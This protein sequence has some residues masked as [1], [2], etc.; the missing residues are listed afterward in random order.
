MTTLKEKMEAAAREERFEDA[1]RLRDRIGAVERTLERQQ[2]VGDPVAD[3]DVFGLAR[4]GG[5]VELQVLHVREGRVMGAAEYAFSGVQ[6]DDGDIMG[7]F[8]GQYYGSGAERQVPAE[9]LC[10]AEIDD[11]G[12][13]EAL[14]RDRAGRRVPVR[15][16][17]RGSGRELVS[18][19]ERNAEL[20]L[21]RRLAARESIEAALEELR[22]K[23]G[24]AGLPRRVEC[25]DVSNL[26]GALPVASRV[27]FESGQAR[28][29][30]YRRY[31]IRDARG[32]DD[33]ACI[34][35]V[36]QRRLARIATEPLPDLLVVD[37][38]KGQLG[39]VTALLADRGLQVD[40]LGIAKQRD[41]ESASPRVRRSRG[42]K[43]ERLFLPG[44]KDAVRLP[45]SSRGLLL[46]QRVRDESHRFAIDYQ[47][48]LRRKVG[49]QS[50]LEELPGIGPGKRRALLRA[51]GSLRAVRGASV[52]ELC[53]VPGIS[54]RDARTI[55]DFFQ[56]AAQTAL[57]A[58]VEGSKVPNSG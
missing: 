47:R 30:D 58:G 1:A 22:E 25:Y 50:I 41:E 35:E 7:S 55:H 15:A 48:S 52:E 4:D 31:K 32:G 39:V 49:L 45:A 56:A 46:L 9:V 8:L 26:Q 27:V 16:P 23:L 51:L 14:L 43:A 19:A 13:L 34:R 37:G 20:G 53:A 38:G 3:R 10:A 40:H 24:L 6:L 12:A 11:G 21:A 5:E 42:L 18:I 33:L 17:K 54:R 28:K 2:I 36:M 44:R 29:A 57:G